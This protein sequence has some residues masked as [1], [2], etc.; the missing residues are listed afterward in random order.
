MGRTIIRWLPCLFF[1]STLCIAAEPVVST[2]SDQSVGV[3]QFTRDSLLRQFDENRNGKLDAGEKQA[4]RVAF[5][6]RDVPMLPAK[7][8]NYRHFTRPK[9][10]APSQLERADNSPDDN[11]LTDHGATLG[12]VLFYDRQLSGNSSISCASCHQQQAG[13]SDPDQF[14]VGFQGGR[15][16]RNSMGLPNIRFTHLQGRRP[17]FFWDERAPTLEAQVL[18]PIQDKVE[19]GMELKDLEIKLGRLPYYPPLFTAAFGS[20][21]VTSKRI[22]QAVAQFMRS[23]VSL[24]AKYDRSA[25]KAESLGDATDFPGFTEQENL[26]KRLFMEGVGGIAEFACA[27]CHIPPTFNMHKSSNIGLELHY[28]DPGLGALERPSNATFTPSN[29]GKF[30][31]SSLRNVELTGPYMHDGRFKT[32]E[33]VVEH[34]SGQIHPHP[35]LGLALE[36]PETEHAT[37]GLQFTLQQKAALVAFLKTLTDRRFV[38]DQR[39]VDPFIREEK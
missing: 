29:D 19:M 28:K 22:S 6:G 18:M 31:A 15:T 9:H 5:G 36:E 39:F 11:P 1:A 20:P 3:G 33:Q 17:G 26:G 24:D 16:K 30:R 8:Y 7:P 2:R 32:L 34:Y 37:S 14:S 21:R 27:M 10:V 38:S 25:V 23:M 4:L 12:R 13:F 35:N